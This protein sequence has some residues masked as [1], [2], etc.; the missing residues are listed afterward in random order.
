MF[1]HVD[2]MKDKLNKIAN[3]KEANA[4]KDIIEKF[5]KECA[6]YK[7]SWTP[8]FIENFNQLKAFERSN[9]QRNPESADQGLSVTFAKTLEPVLT[10]MKEEP[11]PSL[12]KMNTCHP[13]KTR[14]GP[15]ISI[16][17]IDSH[18]FARG[19]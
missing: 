19:S 13:R 9:E 7:A 5:D 15:M 12:L 3:S 1:S 6:S 16:N 2:A 17:S 4:V 8:S 11:R 10:L 14:L 18:G